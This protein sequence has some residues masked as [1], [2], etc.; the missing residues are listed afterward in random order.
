MTN[1]CSLKFLRVCLFVCL[2][3]VGWKKSCS[4]NY[5]QACYSHGDLKAK[6]AGNIVLLF[7]QHD[8]RLTHLHL[9]AESKEKGQIIGALLG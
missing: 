3:V 9:S 8:N 1:L 7:K 6:A 2:F 4:I 5:G